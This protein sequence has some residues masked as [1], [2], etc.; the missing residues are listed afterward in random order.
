ML[1]TAPRITTRAL[2]ALGTLGSFLLAPVR[3]EDDLTP[4]TKALIAKLRE[5]TKS[6]TIAT[7][8]SA[9]KALGE[10]GEKAKGHRRILCEGM[11]DSN[12]SVR[13]AAAD[14]LKKVDEPIYKLALGIV[15][16]KRDEHF[17]AA[18]KLGAHAEPLAPLILAHATALVPVASKEPG[19]IENGKARTSVC[20][21][22]GALAAIAPDDQ[23][24]NQAVIAMLGNPSVTLRECALGHVAPL[25]NKKLALKGVLTIAGAMT[26]GPVVRARAVALVP[27]LVDENTAPATKK[28]LTGLRF[29]TEGLVREAVAKALDDIK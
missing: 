29:D 24:V 25:K 10:L 4:E 8:T 21:A 13:T 12:T 16:D 27:L 18:A 3:A 2:L 9:Y 6:K 1:V 22:V 11:L 7:R 20:A 5:D 26:E 14:A 23:R 17:R 19:T 28:T 15:I